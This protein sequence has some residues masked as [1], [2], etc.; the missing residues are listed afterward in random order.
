MQREWEEADLLEPCAYLDGGPMDI[1]HHNL[2]VPYRGHLVMP[3]A[4]E[5]AQTG[6]VA[7]F[8]MADPCAP[9]K[10]GQG[11]DRAMRETHAMGFVQLLDGPHVGE[12]GF[13]NAM[14]NVFDGGIQSW[15]LSEAEAPVAAGYL[16]T[17]GFLYPD[18]YARITMSLFLQYPWLYVA[19]ADTGIFVV[20]VSDPRSPVLAGE[21]V[22]DV[23]LRAGGIFA[24][25]D[26]L[27]VTA[28]EGST[29]ALLDVSDPAS[30]QAILGGTFDVLDRDGVA[31]DFY[32]ANLAGNLAVF[33][34]KEDGGGP[35]VWDISDPSAPVFWADLPIQGRSGGYVSWDGGR[36]FVG[37]SSRSDVVDF[38]NPANPVILASID[39][40][41]DLDTL[42]P[43][44][45]VAIPSC[46][47]DAVDG[48]ATAV[49]PWRIDPDRS[50][51]V[52]LA[53]RPL[54]GAEGVATT[55]RIGLGW[56]E[57][58]EPA[59]AFEG[60]VRLV[61]VGTEAPVRGWVSTQEN[62]VSYAPREP[63]KRGTRYRVSVEA[64]GIADIHG[65]MVTQPYTFEFETAP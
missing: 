61:E 36:A 35:I 57:M 39:L 42:V 18:A 54:D 41:G 34:R 11:M 23:A 51:P 14:Q 52:L 60:S 65:N 5:S 2:V 31:R 15:D 59:S 48:Q 13:V 29:V 20:D 62:T 37:G 50:A 10:V 55:V 53:H 49:V 27:M 32:H 38:R 45:N 3:F 63:L 56:D 26:I 22:F 12:W 9:V 46:D 44:G 64:R 30:P 40:E 25:G 21:Y 1:D 6:G 47:A 16:A 58:I 4:P 28:A 43:W 33:A 17:P 8:D 24:L 19:A 7:L